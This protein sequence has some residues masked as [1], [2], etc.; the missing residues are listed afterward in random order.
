MDE[1]KVKT[2]QI[3]TKKRTIERDEQTK[4]THQVMKDNIMKSH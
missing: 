1:S 2:I 4:N 3:I